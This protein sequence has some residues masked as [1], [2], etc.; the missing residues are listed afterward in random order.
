MPQELVD[1]HIKLLRKARKT[2]FLE[3]WEKALIKFCHTYS[4]QDGWEIERFGYKKSKLEVKLRALKM[5][6]EGQFDLNNKFKASINTLES[7]ELR[8]KPL[9]RDRNGRI[10]WLQFD[11]VS[12][13]RVYRE[14]LDEESWTLV[15]QDRSSLIQLL[16]ELSGDEHLL[17]LNLLNADAISLEVDK[18]LTD[19][20]QSNH[21]SFTAGIESN[22]N[23]TNSS[24]ENN[25][26]EAKK[27]TENKEN[28]EEDASKNTDNISIMLCENK[29]GV[30][31][32]IN[33]KCEKNNLIQLKTVEIK[34][35]YVFDSNNGTEKPINKVIPY[36]N[37]EDDVLVN[38][39]IEEP[40][41][42][43]VGDGSGKDCM[44]GNPG[45]EQSEEDGQKVALENPETNEQKTE[46]VKE[47]FNVNVEKLKPPPKLWS[48]DAICGVNSSKKIN[49]CVNSSNKTENLDIK[50]KQKNF[51]SFSI[52][53]VLE[54]KSLISFDSTSVSK[55]SFHSQSDSI[56][57]NKDTIKNTLDEKPTKSIKSMEIDVNDAPNIYDSCHVSSAEGG[58]TEENN[59]ECN[60][61]KV[62]QNK[63]KCD[64]FPCVSLSENKSDVADSDVSENSK[65]FTEVLHEEKKN[66]NEF[67]TEVKNDILA[68][69]NETLQKTESDYEKSVENI[70]RNEGTKKSELEKTYEITDNDSKNI[71]VSNEIS[72]K[73]LPTSSVLTSEDIF[74]NDSKKI[75]ESLL[76]GKET[77][78]NVYKNLYAFDASHEKSPSNELKTK[79]CLTNVMK[80]ERAEKVERECNFETRGANF[81]GITLREGIATNEHVFKSIT[82]NAKKIQEVENTASCTRF[83]SQNSETLQKDSQLTVPIPR[84]IVDSSEKSNPAEIP[85]EDRTVIFSNI[86]KEL[87]TSSTKY[88]DDVSNKINSKFRDEMHN[89]KKEPKLEETIGLENCE[90]E[91]KN[92]ELKEPVTKPE[93]FEF[94]ID[95]IKTTSG[96]EKR[97]SELD[98][99]SKTQN[100]S[101]GVTKNQ[102]QI[103]LE[104]N[105]NLNYEEQRDSNELL[106]N[107]KR[108][109]K[110]PSQRI[111]SRNRKASKEENK[112]EEKL[113]ETDKT[114]TKEKS[115]I[116][117][118]IDD[119]QKF[120]AGNCE[121]KNKKS[122]ETS[123]EED[124]VEIRNSENKES[125]DLETQ[126]ENE[127]ES[128]KD[129][130]KA[131]NGEEEITRKGL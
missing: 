39:V 48:I 119:E 32:K 95:K 31:D 85:A 130:P 36:E 7:D 56:H 59:V 87:E 51:S 18:P 82:S 81:D 11:P 96:F 4:S 107:K 123:T 113:C 52:D 12:N 61:Q 16:Q 10:Y 60:E 90:E 44:T 50:T 109:Q 71:K 62:D 114:K 35:N 88:D 106:E 57:F 19:T 70:K 97:E 14:D 68:N 45:K 86:V 105:S 128:A 1:L 92:M 69:I 27:F 101:L 66:S 6:L 131:K 9:G 102:E 40:V 26:L 72:E 55:F 129:A 83:C 103:V 89:T 21:A 120:N 28:L 25:S 63:E 104:D 58:K 64:I 43:I 80:T 30:V 13:I 29:S 8:S 77:A 24:V 33:Q 112:A 42:Y 108:K 37:I 74:Q 110:V 98:Q 91:S 75:K 79:E 111:L 115:D 118:T 94:A 127:K 49:Q 34:D 3:K 93:N 15:A 53:S 41:M 122:E 47:T 17:D 76:Q 84:V 117:E 23:N 46:E 100:E 99:G 65:N 78:D 67:K 22:T 2:V 5:L 54:K 73:N 38:E 20:G 116:K 125:G 121:L 126:I 124:H